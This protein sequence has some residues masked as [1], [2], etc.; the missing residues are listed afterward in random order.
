MT[1]VDV[2]DY[3]R[4]FEAIPSAT[5]YDVMDERGLGD[6]CCLDHGIRP[7]VPG[8][9]RTG[10]AV[11]VRWVRD[12]RTAQEWRPAELRR[13]SDYFDPITAGS[14][15]V[16]DGAGETG[17]GQWGEMLSTMAWLRGARGVVVDGGTRDSKGIESLEGFAAFARF[18]SPIE[19]VKRLRIHEM[20]APLLLDGA[21]GARVLVRPGDWV[22]ADEDAVLVVPHERVTEILE[23]SEA[24]EEI[25]LKARTD[26]RAGVDINE[27]FRRYGRA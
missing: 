14:I 13:M 9:R 8:M 18:T 11:T 21:L 3:A 26:L 16:V 25:E 5:I 6:T 17:T 20:Q 4:R 23:A 1:E 7:L 15:V 24:L 2:A 12:P 22:H 19:S 27:V 10:P